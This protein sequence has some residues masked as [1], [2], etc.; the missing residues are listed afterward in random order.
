MFCTNCGKPLPDDSAFCSRCGKSTAVRAPAPA[1]PP[2]YTPQQTYIAPQ[3]AP[4]APQPAPVVPPAQPRYAPAQPYYATPP[5]VAAPPSM[6]WFKFLINFYLFFNSTACIISG[7]AIA[8]GLERENAALLY[9]AVPGLQLFEINIGVLYVLLG[10]F[11]VLTRF[12]LSGRYRN[13]PKF[14]AAF[15]IASSAWEAQ[16]LAGNFIFTPNVFAF[17]DVFSVLSVSWDVVT[18]IGMPLALLFINLA[19]FK[20]RAFLF[21]K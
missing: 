5:R 8:L 2:V 12:R 6:K 17:T 9:H 20:K 10:T 4:V 18:T 14:L 3:P 13:G 7:V 15:F 19:Y 16:Y 11:G 1:P 21:V